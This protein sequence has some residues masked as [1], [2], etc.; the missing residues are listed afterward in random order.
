MTEYDKLD[1]AKIKNALEGFGND[2]DITVLESVDSTNTYA[3][4]IADGRKRLVTSE[5]QT[6]GRGRLGKSFFSPCG[7]GIY[8]SLVLPA[9]DNKNPVIYTVI[10]AVAAA[11]V[12]E[13][14]ADRE[15]KIKWV[16]DI[17]SGGKKVCPS[18][19]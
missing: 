7:K 11:R 13:K 10:A 5:F 18:T 8:M 1:G 3:K 16:N 17:F 2:V 12:I 4:G 6:A 9:E 14:I 15:A 19:K